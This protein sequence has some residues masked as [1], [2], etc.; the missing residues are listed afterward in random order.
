MPELDAL[1]QS[2]VIEAD[3]LIR[4]GVRRVLNGTGVIHVPQALAPTLALLLRQQG[5]RLLTPNGNIVAIGA[6]YPGT[7]PAGAAPT[8]GTCWM[9]ATG[10]IFMYRGAP[11]MRLMDGAAPVNRTNDTVKAIIERTYLLGYDC[12]LFGQLV[13]TASFIATSTGTP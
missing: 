13:N 9:Y 1:A 12:C 10:P 8:L 3:A 11:N 7:S 5:G 4:G 2:V 6:G